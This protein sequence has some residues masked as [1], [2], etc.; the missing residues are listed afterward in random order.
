M[1]RQMPEDREL[2]TSERAFQG[3]WGHPVQG[4][5][6]GVSGTVVELKAKLKHQN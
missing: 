5:N 4:I 6:G 2:S 3:K 1:G